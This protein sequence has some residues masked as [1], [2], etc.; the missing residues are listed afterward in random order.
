MFM[1]AEFLFT[2][3][4]VVTVYARLVHGQWKTWRRGTGPA[5]NSATRN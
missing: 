5:Q 2:F 1:M 4:L 3:G